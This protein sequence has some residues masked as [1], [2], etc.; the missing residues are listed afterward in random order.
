MNKIAIAGAGHGGLVAAAKLA[1]AGFDV[2][3]YEKL[4]RDELGHD[5]EDRFNFKNLA[6]ALDIDEDNLPKDSWRFRGD[7][8]FVS[9]AGR[10]SVLIRYDETNRQKVMWRKSII[11][12]L[13]EYAE[14]CGVEFCYGVNVTAPVVKDGYV[15]GFKT[16]DGVVQADLT[17]DAA[18]VFSPLRTN[19]SPDFGIEN[20]PE[21]GDVFYAYRAYF[22]RKEGF[23]TPP[24]PFEIFLY[25]EGEQGLSWC[26]TNEN[27]VDVLIGRIDKIDKGVV[28]AQMQIFRR[29]HP[30]IGD[31][32]LHGG[33]YGAI[34]VRRPLAQ[35]VCNGYAAVGDSAFMTTPMNGM[36]IDLSMKAGEMLADCVIKNKDKSLS[37][38]A[39]W[40][41]NRDFHKLYG[42]ATA[43]NEG[44]KNSLL[45]LPAE[46]VDFLFDNAVIQS[47]DLAGAGRNTKISALLGKFVRGMKK[48]A[49]FFAILKG[50]I[51][52]A[53][54]AKIY[55]N[56]PKIYDEKTILK[57]KEK[58]L[59][60]R[61]VINRVVENLKI[62]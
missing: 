2:T 15:V 3:V 53:K 35:F 25:H 27:N 17:V 36:G 24:A 60:C 50:L 13:I 49:Y 12:L 20:E 45:E 54:T 37:V 57:W 16:D 56:A 48:P 21:R 55:K 61:I 30:W 8:A 38:E 5:W 19:L 9:P 51:K 47:S 58:I 10:T 32:I 28:D 62:N 6:G 39:L 11:N 7:C 52:G 44:L 29:K 4:K 42:G 34:P 1:K 26:C 59:D 46:G 14:K 18:G 22:E 33:T 41:Y 40:E 23:Q 43:K 31:K